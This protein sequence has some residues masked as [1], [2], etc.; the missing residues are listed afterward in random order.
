[1]ISIAPRDVFGSFTFAAFTVKNIPVVVAVMIIP[2][3]IESSM[4]FFQSKLLIL[5]YIFL[6]DMTSFWWLILFFID[7]FFICSLRIVICKKYAN[8]NGKENK[9]TNAIDISITG[10]DVGSAVGRGGS[11]VGGADS[12]IV[13]IATIFFYII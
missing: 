8:T 9:Y 1:M 13:C 5:L 3:L 12:F 11:T 4:F 7:F 10:G 2:S 6:K